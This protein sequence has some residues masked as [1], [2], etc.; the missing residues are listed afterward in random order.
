MIFRKVYQIFELG[1]KST[2]TAKILTHISYHLEK[3]HPQA[4]P[5][6][7]YLTHKTSSYVKFCEKQT[8][9]SF[10]ESRGIFERSDHIQ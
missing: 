7:E 3:K 8:E 10:L 9:V 5:F 6:V 1:E 2:L 4:L